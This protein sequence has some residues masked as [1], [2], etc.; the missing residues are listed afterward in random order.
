MVCMV[1]AQQ[2]KMP[3]QVPGKM[4]IEQGRN[5]QT[6]RKIA[7]CA[8]QDKICIVQISGV[9]HVMAFEW[10]CSNIVLRS[11]ADR[12]RPE[13]SNATKDR[14]LRRTGQNMYRADQWRVS[15]YGFRVVMLKHSAQTQCFVLQDRLCAGHRPAPRA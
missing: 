13:R 3:G 7:S 6:P 10:L 2:Q 14:L 9:F 4:Q 15:C 5:D 8:E 11:D 12:T 1:H